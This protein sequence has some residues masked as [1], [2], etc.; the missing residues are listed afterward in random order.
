MKPTNGRAWGAIVALAAAF[1]F[2]APTLFLPPDSPV[3]PKL[4]FIAVGAVLFV[5][6]VVLTRREPGSRASHDDA[7]DDVT[8]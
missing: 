7:R 8:P 5:V 4:V 2:A 3:G 1:V 6:A